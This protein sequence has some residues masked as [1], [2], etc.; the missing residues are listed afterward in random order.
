M[1]I[2]RVRDRA[3]FLALEILVTAT[4]RA[5]QRWNPSF[6]KSFREVVNQKT[7]EYRLVPFRD[8][9]SPEEADLLAAEFHEAW[10]RQTTRMLLKPGE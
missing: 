5:L 2:E 10:V 1:D 9:G 6:A 7:E 8:A 3:E 4:V